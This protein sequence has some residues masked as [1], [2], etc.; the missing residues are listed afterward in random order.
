[1][2]VVDETDSGASAPSATP[3]SDQPVRR[4]GDLRLKL[5]AVLASILLLSFVGYAVSRATNTAPS[6]MTFPSSSPILL[7]AGRVAPAFSLAR[8]GGGSTVSLRPLLKKPIVLNFFASWCPDCRQELAAF[9][10]ISNRDVS[11]VQFVGIDTSDTNPA[12]ASSLLAHADA[13][14]P[15]G[16]DR[17]GAVSSAYL[18]SDLPVTLFIDTRGRVVGELYGTQTKASLTRAIR[19]L[20]SISA[21][22]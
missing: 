19:G 7:K 9:A 17:R 10:T 8:L 1:M 6:T 15:V 16:I 18:V 22:P 21:S 12:L 11:E 20:L 3:S 4:R 2:S 13:H 14:Y 5:T